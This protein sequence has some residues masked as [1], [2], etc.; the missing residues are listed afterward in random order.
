MNG[1]F[2]LVDDYGS[3]LECICNRVCDLT[4]FIAT[5][6]SHKRAGNESAIRISISQLRPKILMVTSAVGDAPSLFSIMTINV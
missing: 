3:R 6:N 4:I 2:C 1:I 5:I